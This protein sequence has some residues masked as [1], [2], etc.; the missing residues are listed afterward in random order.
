MLTTNNAQL[1]EQEKPV[2]QSTPFDS[3]ITLSLLHSKGLENNPALHQYTINHNNEP[4]YHMTPQ[5]ALHASRLSSLNA[6][7]RDLLK[8]LNLQDAAE[9]EREM[10]RHVERLHVYNEVKDCGQALIGRLAVIRETTSK[11]LY[12]DFGLGLND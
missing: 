10:S 9:A 8:Q 5:A 11:A 1:S 2:E 3:P 4:V 12:E 7:N 6:R